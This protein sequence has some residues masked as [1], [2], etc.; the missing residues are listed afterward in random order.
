[1][2]RRDLWGRS[3]NKNP[4]EDWDIYEE[5]TGS[6]HAGADHAGV[7]VDLDFP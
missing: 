5:I 7:S 6:V 1:V 4:P 2:F 3:T